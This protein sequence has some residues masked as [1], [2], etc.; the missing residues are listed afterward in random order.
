MEPTEL[1]SLQQAAGG[2]PR[3]SVDAHPTLALCRPPVIHFGDPFAELS[4]VAQG[5]ALFDVSDRVQLQLIGPDAKSFLNSFC[6]NNIASLEAGCGCEAFVTNVKGRVL[7][8]VAVFV[9][10]R[11]LWLETGPCDEDALVAHFDRYVIREKVEFLRHTKDLGELLL[12]GPCSARLLH[13]VLG[14]TGELGLWQHGLGQWADEAVVVRRCGIVL[15]PGYLVSAIRSF[16][17]QL[18]QAFVQAGAVAAGAQV[19]HACRIQAG[20]PLYGVDLTVDNFAQ[21]AGRT[22][23]AISFTKGCYLGQ[24]PIARLDALGHVNRLLCSLD[25]ASESP[26]EP[27]ARVVN[28]Q[29]ETVGTVTSAARLMG[30]QRSVALALLRAIHARPGTSLSVVIAEQSYS[31]SVA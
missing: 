9:T 27:G 7:N 26:P 25:I 15:Q 17:P 28:D 4:A 20:Y 21:E 10:D 14:L 12:A 29:G 5:T 6:T 19:F 2:I 18:W 1:D 3:N 8:H 30:S 16:L 31:A 24:E 11:D 23:E 22:T 13:D